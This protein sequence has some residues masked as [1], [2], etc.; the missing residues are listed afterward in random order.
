M[1]KQIKSERLGIRLTPEHR[2]LLNSLHALRPRVTVSHLIEAVT[3]DDVADQLTVI[4]SSLD[5]IK[6]GRSEKKHRIALNQALA[7]IKEITK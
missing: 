2:D 5:A 4:F 6:K 1:K 3:R 7:K